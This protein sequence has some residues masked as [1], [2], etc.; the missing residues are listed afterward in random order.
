MPVTWSLCTSKWPQVAD[1]RIEYSQYL[2][3]RKHIDPALGP[4]VGAPGHHVTAKLRTRSC[5]HS[6]RSCSDPRPLVKQDSSHT[7]CCVA[8][9]LQLSRFRCGICVGPERSK[10][11]GFS[12][13]KLQLDS[14]QHKPPVAMD[15]G[16]SSLPNLNA[17]SWAGARVPAAL[18]FNNFKAA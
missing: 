11:Q 13:R 4:L 16:I 9:E 7:A 3:V 1:Q 10:L 14:R 6:C 8:L 15:H 5:C 12:G 2:Q 18:E 17:D